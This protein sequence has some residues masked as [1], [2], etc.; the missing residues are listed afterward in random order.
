VWGWLTRILGRGGVTSSHGV[1][2]VFD[3]DNGFLRVIMWLAVL[4]AAWYGL[5]FFISETLEGFSRAA[6]L[7]DS[8]NS[9]HDGTLPQV[10]VCNESPVNCRCDAFYHPRLRGDHTRAHTYRHARL[11]A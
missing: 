3:H 9:L 7:T 6:V 4:G 10:T 5:V 2:Q 8:A 1:N 11:Q